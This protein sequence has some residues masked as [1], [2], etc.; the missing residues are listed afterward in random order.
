MRRD[1]NVVVGSGKNWN[2]PVFWAPLLRFI[3]APILAI[4]F[5]F[6][7]PEFHGLRNDPPYIV[8]FILAHIV[9]L[10]ILIGFSLPRYLDV[11]IPPDRRED[12]MK[13]YGANV[14]EGLLE[15]EP[16]REMESGSGYDTSRK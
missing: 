15:A 1:L 12:G 6:A 14:V 11:F 16:V 3:S 7:Y 5:S 10:T 4:V 8:G 9:I 2:I 13:D